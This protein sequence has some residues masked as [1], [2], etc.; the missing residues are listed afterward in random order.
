LIRHGATA[1]NAARRFQGQ[2]DVELSEAGREQARAIAARLKRESIDR[3]YAS[4]LSRAFETASI[5]AAPH[6]LSVTP[7]P[8]L[9]EFA[10]GQWEGLTWDEIVA[11]RP[12]LAELGS[13][14]A[15]LYTP[16][17]GESFEAVCARVRSFLNDVR[18][19]AGHAAVVTHAGPLHAMFDVLGIAGQAGDGAHLGLSFSPAGVTHVAMEEGIA[20]LITLNDVR[21]L[22]TSG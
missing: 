8:R 17:E 18:E 22:D 4:D 11:T 2:S 15:K 5:V 6:G 7:D 21:H 3:V 13:T 20:R 10:F 19:E 12:H 16:E 9:R 14:A 1:W